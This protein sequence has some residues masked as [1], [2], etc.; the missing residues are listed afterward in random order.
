MKVFGELL[1]RHHGLPLVD[2]NFVASTADEIVYTIITSD[3]SIAK[4]N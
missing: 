4:I 1:V 3:T 2:S